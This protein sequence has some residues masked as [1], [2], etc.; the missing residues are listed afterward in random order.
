MLLLITA[1]SRHTLRTD[2][3]LAAVLAAFPFA[4]TYG[5]VY[6]GEQYIPSGLA[7]V[8]FGVLPLYVALLGAAL[9][10]DQP[11]RARVV[12][13]VLVAIAGLVL[14]F[15]ESIDLGDED[16]ALAG[17]AALAIAPMGAAV[18]NISIKLR[19][20][21]LDAVVLNGWAML[22]AGLAL[23]AVSA[24][25]ESWGDAAWTGKSIGSIAYLALIGSA[26][27]F[28]GLTILLR[29]ITAQAMSFLAMLLPFGALAFGAV[30]YDESI[31]GRALGGAALVAGGLLIAQALPARARGRAGG[32]AGLLRLGQDPVER[33][34]RLGQDLLGLLG[35]L[36]RPRLRDL[37]RRRGELPDQRAQLDELAR[38]RPRRPR[39][40]GC[41]ALAV[42]VHVGAALVGQ[43]EGAAARALVR[44][45]QALVLEL[46][47]RGVDRARAGAPG[48]VAA[49]LDL[50]HQPVAV[51][52]LLFEQQQH[53]SADVAAAGARAP[54]AGAE[55]HAAPGAVPEGARVEVVRG[56]GGRV[57]SCGAALGPSRDVV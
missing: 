24:V 42:L 48:A 23:L 1:A 18:G 8:L 27:P 14:A 28:V 32:G 25:G 51:A 3:R 50:L 13:G 21:A 6:W 55:A 39:P 49:A 15:V 30:L 46:G 19:A 53:G 54:A 41:R 29:H 43:L 20:G 7:A 26:V 11:L 31:T 35:L 22:G 44:T 33:L 17:A 38:A 9:L 2:F 34:A 5:L 4:L 47:E 56:R 52:G 12:V 16:L 37:N 10:P 57:G 36:R 45:D 40:T